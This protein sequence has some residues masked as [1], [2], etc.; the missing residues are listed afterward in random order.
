MIGDAGAKGDAETKKDA[1]Q[2]V[3]QVEGGWDMDGC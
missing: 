1:E 2:R 3:G